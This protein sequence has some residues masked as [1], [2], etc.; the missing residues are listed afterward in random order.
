VKLYHAT[1]QEKA[2]KILVNGFIDHE[3]LYM[4]SIWLKGIFFSNYP[5]D[6]N[7]GAKGRVVLTVK[8]PMDIITDYEL[9]EDGK[10]YR[11]WC[12]PAEIVNRYSI[13]LFDDL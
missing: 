2:N 12:I 4:T 8:I 3:G 6:E 10:P 7:E 1:T 5:L 9:I 13:T 11:E